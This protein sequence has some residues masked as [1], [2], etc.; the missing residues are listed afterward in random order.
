MI[1]SMEHKVI[2]YILLH[3]STILSGLTMHGIQNDPGDL[4]IL[5]RMKLIKKAY[6]TMMFL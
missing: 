6:V 3:F 4:A 5:R 1:L 2:K